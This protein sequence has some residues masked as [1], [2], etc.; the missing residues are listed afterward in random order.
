MDKVFKKHKD[1]PVIYLY[2]VDILDIA[3][4][5]QKYVFDR[6]LNQ[7]PEFVVVVNKLDIANEKYLN[8]HLILQTIRNRMLEFIEDRESPSKEEMRE[9]INNIKVF[10]TSNINKAGIKGLEGH[11]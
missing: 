1:L 11:I 4:S 10:L 8:K 7:K 2:V 9:R 6:L 5:F 3:G